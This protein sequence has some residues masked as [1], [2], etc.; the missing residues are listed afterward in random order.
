VVWLPTHAQGCEV[1]RQ[2]RA[3]HGTLVS[4]RSQP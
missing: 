2:L 3:G 1:R 4:L